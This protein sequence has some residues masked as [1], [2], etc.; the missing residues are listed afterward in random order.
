MEWLS[1]SLLTRDLEWPTLSRPRPTPVVVVDD[2]VVG[3]LDLVVVVGMAV[4]HRALPAFVGVL[5]VLVVDV[6]V[7]MVL[8]GVAVAQPGGVA[9]GPQAPGQSRRDGRRQSQ[10]E[11]GDGEVFGTAEPAGQG[12]GDQ[13]AGVRQRELGR[14][15][16]SRCAGPPTTGATRT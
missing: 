13:P 8:G 1:R 9:P 10:Q 7:R 5:V 12:I 3:V 2:E 11:E 16:G 4:R 6:Q 14:K 15:E